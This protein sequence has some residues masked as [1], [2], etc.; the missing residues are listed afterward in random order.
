MRYTGCY[1]EGEVD[2]F[3]TTPC[4]PDDGHLGGNM[5]DKEKPT[6]EY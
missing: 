3:I 4:T 5:F 6:G 1:D 2:S